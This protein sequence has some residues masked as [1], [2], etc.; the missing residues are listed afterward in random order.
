MPALAQKTLLRVQ[1]NRHP[2]AS[3]GRQKV[4]GLV[5]CSGRGLA[6]LSYARQ[7]ASQKR[8]LERAGVVT[9]H[10]CGD[11]SYYIRI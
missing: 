2:R 9:V 3:R 10:T 5:H 4:G 7:N 11:Q 8:A 6:T 1:Q